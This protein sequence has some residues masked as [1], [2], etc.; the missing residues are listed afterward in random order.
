[1]DGTSVGERIEPKRT[2][3]DGTGDGNGDGVDR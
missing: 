2:E 1:M 3:R